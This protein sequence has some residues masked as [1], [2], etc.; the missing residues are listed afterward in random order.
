MVSSANIDEINIVLV[1]ED[2][3]QDVVS[4]SVTRRK[5]KPTKVIKVVRFYSFH[6]KYYKRKRTPTSSW[7]IIFTSMVT[8]LV[9]VLQVKQESPFDT[10]PVLMQTFLAAI[11][12][13]SAVLGIK[14]RTQNHTGSYQPQILKLL[15]LLSGSLSSASL[16]AILLHR[17]LFWV[18]FITWGFVPLIVAR[19]FLK[20]SAYWVSGLVT[21]FTKNALHFMSATFLSMFHIKQQQQQQD[22]AMNNV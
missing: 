1:E 4:S 10:H 18:L 19:E 16:L 2:N 14:I 6:K 21:R 7:H 13:N 9:S 15:L 20:C 17:Q 11:S 12:I 3:H 8:L 22:L 5:P